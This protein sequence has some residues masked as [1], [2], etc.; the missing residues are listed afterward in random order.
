MS[1]FAQ[2]LN[3]IVSNDTASSSAAAAA[4]APAAKRPRSSSEKDGMARAMSIDE[5]NAKL[6][7]DS[8][9]V[10]SKK[11]VVIRG[12]VA[13]SFDPM[14][15]DWVRLSDSR[16]DRSYFEA[17][18][19]RDHVYAIGTYNMTAAGT[20]ERLSLSDNRWETCAPLPAK[21]RSVA[22]SAVGDKI[23]VTGGMDVTTMTPSAAVHVFDPS[24]SAGGADG[25]GDVGA[26]VAAPQSMIIPRYR[27]ASVVFQ[28]KL[29]AVGGIIK[30][31]YAMEEYTS[32]TECLDLAKNE[33]APG[34][35]LV[36]RRAIDVSP[37]VVN[38]TLY[39]VGGDMK[40]VVH[41]SNA[42]DKQ[43]ADWGTIERFDPEVQQFVTVTRFRVQ[44]RGFSAAAQGDKIYIF[45][46]R[47]GDVDLT[48]WDVFDVV[49]GKW[50]ATDVQG[51]TM[52]MDSLWG[53]AVAL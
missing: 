16:R 6:Q 51:G 7:R 42:C 24:V 30:N 18:L 19:L 23:F 21:L 15:G 47:D 52:P 35:S 25:G 38:N 49:V 10:G 3:K 28:N 2:E 46:G 26:W 32:T 41:H 1:S 43:S 44:R 39:I 5:Y 29:W 36:A 12:F 17:V 40:G 9:L 48:S 27:H 20:V 13:Y 34:P 50:R 22:A 53:R 14:S 11:I 4:A 33:W 31:S 8:Q 45:G 37:L